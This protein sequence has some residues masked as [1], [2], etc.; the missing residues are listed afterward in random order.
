MNS[1]KD[2]LPEDI[3]AQ[4]LDAARDRFRTYGYNKTTMAEI[5][6]DCEMSAANLYRYFENKLDI[7]A[8]LACNCLGNKEA[9]LATVQER[10]DLSAAEKLQQFVL[11]NLR[12][13]HN[14]TSETPRINEMVMA[15]CQ[16]QMDIVNQHMQIKKELLIKLIEQG[17]VSGEFDV[18][19]PPQAAKAIL[20]AITIF[21]VP[22]FMSMYS[23]EHMEHKAKNLVALLLSGLR[24]R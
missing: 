6:K 5:A 17:N 24:K 15:I 13:T 19:E 4:I 9:I 20:D 12:E 2:Q 8:N 23:L 16:S 14:Q 21:D 3:R 1:A 22:T 11:E 18:L 10:C 7:G